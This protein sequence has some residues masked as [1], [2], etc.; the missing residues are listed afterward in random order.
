[1]RAVIFLLLSTGWDDSV[2]PCTEA[3]TAPPPP[4]LRLQYT[5]ILSIVDP[6]ILIENILKG[7]VLLCRRSA[8]ISLCSAP[9]PT[10][11]APL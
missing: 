10:L 4:P 1:M 6:R 9:L 11:P 8:S 2:T 7:Y 5:Y 3:V